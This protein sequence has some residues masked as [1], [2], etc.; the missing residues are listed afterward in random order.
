[1]RKTYSVQRSVRGFRAGDD[2]WDV[3]HG[4]P[5]PS[6]AGTVYEIPPFSEFSGILDPSGEPI[7]V[8]YA[9]DPIGFIHWPDES[10]E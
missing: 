5:S 4:S 10:A 8:N 7:M 9:N 2:D 6:L 1:M 3:S